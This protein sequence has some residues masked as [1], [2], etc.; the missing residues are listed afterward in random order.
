MRWQKFPHLSSVASGTLYYYVGAG[1]SMEAGLAG[2]DEMACIVWRHRKHYE[3]DLEVGSCPKAGATERIQDLL[4]DFVKAECAPRSGLLARNAG[5]SPSERRALGRAA[6]LNMLLRYR[7]PRLTTVKKRPKALPAAKSPLRL[8]PGKPPSAEDLTV[9]SLLWRSRCHGVFTTNYDLFL[10][11]AYVLYRH[12]VALRSYRYTATLLRYLLS[13]PN[14]VL[15]LHGDINDIATMEFHPVHAWNSGGLSE[16]GSD[17]TQ[18]PRAVPPSPTHSGGLSGRGSDL[19]DV[20][21]A[22]LRRGH[23]IYLGCGFR[24]ETISQLYGSAV[25]TN[26]QNHLRVALVPSK[27]IRVLGWKRFPSIQF[28]TYE[29]SHEVR[30]FVEEVSS[31]RSEVKLDGPCREAKDLYEQV[32]HAS[33]ASEPRQHQTTAPWTCKSRRLQGRRGG[34]K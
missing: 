32:F 3:Q 30:E 12:G 20:Y 22:A 27:E 7:K 25:H 1:L 28:L 6:L 17:L 8:R 29:Q 19:K 31:L 10:E 11:D 21:A 4:N 14:F 16:C 13:N 24:D 2:W 34:S 15:H 18:P 23:M 26:D 5:E 9:Q 33:Q